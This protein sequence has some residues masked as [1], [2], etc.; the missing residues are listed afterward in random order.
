M[1]IR[2]LKRALPILGVALFLMCGSA[3]AGVLDLNIVDPVQTGFPGQTFVF[4]GSITNNT[5]NTEDETTLFLDFANFDPINLNIQELLD[6]GQS[7]TLL[8]GDTSGLLNLFQITLDP[9]A[10][11]PQVYNADAFLQDNFTAG[12]SVTVT[13]NGVPEP[14]TGFLLS[15]GAAA[16]LALRR[17][18]AHKEESR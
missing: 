4:H 9:A 16:I 10:P 15:I 12:D 18:S 5:G 6:V 3:Q 8:P 7:F 14:A 17:R 13:I 2:N 11:V 1:K